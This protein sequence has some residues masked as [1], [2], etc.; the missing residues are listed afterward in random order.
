MAKTS[1]RG[2]YRQSDLLK[3]QLPLLPL[4]RSKERTMFV[5]EVQALLDATRQ[6]EQTATSLQTKSR[7][8]NI[9]ATWEELL[10]DIKHKI[11]RNLPVISKADN[12]SLAHADFHGKE[13]S[14]NEFIRSISSQVA[15]LL[16][17]MF[18]PDKVDLSVPVSAPDD[19]ELRAIHDEVYGHR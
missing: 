1:I 7:L 16:S 19:P 18:S 15:S 14:P 10:V 9:I 3:D 5:K 13:A 12:T 8:Q 17:H 11:F 6:A 4:M 2:I